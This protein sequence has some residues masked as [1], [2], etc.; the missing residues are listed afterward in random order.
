MNVSKFG[1]DP[2]SNLTH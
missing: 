2:F 1:W